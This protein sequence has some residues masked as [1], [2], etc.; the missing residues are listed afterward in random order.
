MILNLKIESLFK[1]AL[2]S[3]WISKKS[4]AYLTNQNP[5]TPIMYSLPKI[6][7]YSTEPPLRPTVSVTEPLSNMW[8][9]FETVVKD[10][11][12]YLGDT[13]WI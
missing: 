8:I 1:V 9:S 5:V 10:L 4:K 12:C 11:P 2:E 13:M 6:H 3:N 7:K